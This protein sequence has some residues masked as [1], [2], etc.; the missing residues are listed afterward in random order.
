MVALRGSSSVDE[1]D[2]FADFVAARGTAMLR[3]AHLLSAGSTAD[4]EDL[5]QSAL[6][7]LYR[8]W[9][10][11]RRAGDPEPYLRRALVNLA[12]NRSRRHKI[13]QLIAVASPPERGRSDGTEAIE[14]RDVLMAGLRALPA[15]QRAVLVLR[16]WED[17]SVAQTA[18]LLSCSAGTVKSQAARGLAR[19]RRGLPGD[20]HATDAEGAQA[21][22]G[23]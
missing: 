5:L 14:T 16:Y 11:V 6:E 18:E 12:I 7:K 21:H 13:V 4:A 19:L 2:T 15:G 10:R 17:L 23:P 8:H 22:A 20:H 3:V 9:P 1:D